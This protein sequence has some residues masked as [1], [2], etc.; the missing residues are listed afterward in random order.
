MPRTHVHLALTTASPRYGKE[1]G[2]KIIVCVWDEHGGNEETEL[3]INFSCWES[4]NKTVLGGRGR[5]IP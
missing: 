4:E 2:K 1:K 3:I 5:A